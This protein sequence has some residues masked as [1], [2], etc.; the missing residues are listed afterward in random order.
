MMSLGRKDA[1]F[2][3]R[4]GV[5]VGFPI[6]GVCGC[7]SF[8]SDFDAPPLTMQLQPVPPMGNGAILPSP[9]MNEPKGPFPYDG[10][11]IE[12]VPMP[13]LENQPKVQGA[14]RFVSMPAAKKYEFA[15]YGDKQGLKVPPA[16]NAKDLYVKV[17]PRN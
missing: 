14:D 3:D 17:M 5:S 4:F 15:A 12:P 10:G 13:K 6:G 2:F 11:P 8:Q 1:D 9:R 7:S 16:D